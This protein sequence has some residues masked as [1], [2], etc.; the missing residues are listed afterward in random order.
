MPIPK[1]AGRD[2]QR[3]TKALGQ[4]NLARARKEFVHAVRE[5]CLAAQLTS[6]GR[7]DDFGA[8][9]DVL[10]CGTEGG[11]PDS[12]CGMKWRDSSWSRRA[13]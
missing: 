8:T 5:G 10:H 1:G 7:I 6:N 13:C 11:A 9:N 4:G 12:A 3:V 2:W